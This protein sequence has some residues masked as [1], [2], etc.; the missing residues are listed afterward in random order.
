MLIFLPLL[1]FYVIYVLVPCVIVIWMG[2]LQLS[3]ACMGQ[4]YLYTSSI[5]N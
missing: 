4:F 2:S 5:G 3:F 1:L